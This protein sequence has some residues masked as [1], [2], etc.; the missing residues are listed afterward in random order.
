M[1][2]KK[3]FLVSDT[4]S[5]SV[6]HGSP[7]PSSFAEPCR[8]RVKKALGDAVGISQFGV[9]LV[10]LP[11]GTWSS[12][13]HWHENEDEFI[14]VISGEV[15]L[16]SDDGEE[17]LSKGQIVGFP[18][19]IDNGHHLINRSSEPASYIEVGSR[20]AS[21]TVQYPDINMKMERQLGQK[22]LFMDRQ[23]NLL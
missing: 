22:S 18:S 15:V 23:D 11:P 17:T 8:A 2:E 1:Q 12:Q 21:E 10:E 13:R 19:K 3:A 6:R 14:L 5:V 4:A 7:Y 16:L 9:N 20:S